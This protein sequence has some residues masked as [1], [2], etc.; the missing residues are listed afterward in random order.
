M[1]KLTLQM[2]RNSRKM[3]Y[4]GVMSYDGKNGEWQEE[5][6][7]ILP[8]E[9]E[10][11]DCE[12]LS[13]LLKLTIPTD[14]LHGMLLEALRFPIIVVP[15]PLSIRFSLNLPVFPMISMPMIGNGGRGGYECLGD[16][17]LENVDEL[18]FETIHNHYSCLSK[19]SIEPCPRIKILDL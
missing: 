17:R 10:F 15:S 1:L 13:L 8:E 14:S 7:F 6:R 4:S 5:H 18:P 3:I 19:S 12:F 2:D 9:E 16:R 11:D